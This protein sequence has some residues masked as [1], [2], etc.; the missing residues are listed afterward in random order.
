M[1]LD[2]VSCSELKLSDQNEAKSKT[3]FVL[4]PTTNYIKITHFKK[5]CNNTV[6]LCYKLEQKYNHQPCFNLLTI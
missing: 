6:L 2:Q 1:Y 5:N 4:V 3:V